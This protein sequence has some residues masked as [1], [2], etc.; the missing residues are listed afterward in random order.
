MKKMKIKTKLF[1]LFAF[2]SPI[3][4]LAFAEE[5]FDV[6]ANPDSGTYEN[7]TKVNLTA[8]KENVKIFY[9]FNPNATPNDLLEYTG[10]ILIKKTTPLIYFAIE[11]YQSETKIKQNDYTINYSN[12]IKFGT[13]TKL[14]N[15][16]DKQV[17]LSYRIIK[18]SKE[19][20]VLKD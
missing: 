20:Y 19:T 16:G 10:T 6:T 1:F 12:W 18:T 11:N 14:Q 9:S 4:G 2:L 3:L 13:G 17:D 15:S 7:V 5:A 8:S